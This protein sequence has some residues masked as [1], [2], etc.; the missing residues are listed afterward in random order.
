MKPY[1]HFET[2][3]LLITPT[4]AADAAFLVSLMNT[5]GWL[6]YVGD[7]HVHTIAQ[8]TQY[9]AQ[10]MTPQL[11]R[12][13]F[14]NYT[15]CRKVDLVPIGVCGLYDREG[16]DGVDL[17]FALLPEFEGQGFAYEA[18]QKVIWAGKT[19]FDIT[20]I[21]AIT[22][23]E[24]TRS[25]VLLEKLGFQFVK[26]KELPNDDVPLMLYRLDGTHS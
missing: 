26:M 3:R 15:L 24:N 25:Q 19:H 4:D 14:S 2:E 21:Q 13:G 7:R 10:K 20:H 12:L 23:P 16:L 11:K 17:G 22:V 18:A 9:I 6:A 8:A 1:V 5:P